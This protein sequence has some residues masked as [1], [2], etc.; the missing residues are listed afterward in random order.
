LEKLNL[1]S[2]KRE[3]ISSSSDIFLRQIDSSIAQ[4]NETIARNQ[5]KIDNL[6]NTNKKQLEEITQIMEKNVKNWQAEKITVI[7]NI[8]QETLTNLT[9][10]KAFDEEWKY[11]LL[12]ML[13]CNMLKNTFFL[14]EEARLGNDTNLKAASCREKVMELFKKECFKSAKVKNQLLYIDNFKVDINDSYNVYSEDSQFHYK[15]FLQQ[16]DESTRKKYTQEVKEYMTLSRSYKYF[17]YVK[18]KIYQKHAKEITQKDHEFINVWVPLLCTVQETLALTL[19]SD[20]IRDKENNVI[21]K[22]RSC[23]KFDKKN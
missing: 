7:Y 17:H 15:T 19:A 11:D 10:K 5:K 1:N 23:L 14:G 12:K 13:L 9:H 18:E 22:V 21:A 8:D 20:R 6:G 4:D 2:L 3:S 16:L